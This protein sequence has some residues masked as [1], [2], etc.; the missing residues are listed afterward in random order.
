MAVTNVKKQEQYA[1]PQKAV[2]SNKPYQGMNGITQS[3]RNNLGNYQQGYK[4]ADTV[5]QAQQRV[6]QVQAQ[7]PQSYNSKYSGA[8]DS[9]LQQ[10]Q[11]PQDFKY[12]FNGDNLFKYYADLYTQKGRQASMDAMG[13]AAALTGGYGNSWAQAAGNQAYQQ[14]LLDLYGVGMDMRDRAYQQYQDQQANRQNTYN[15]LRDAQ[16]TEY[17]QYRDTVGDWER[18][19]DRA[20]QDYQQ[21]RAFDY[22]QYGDMLNYYTQLA[23]IENAAYNTEA[24]RQEAIRQFNQNFA[25]QQRQYNTTLAEQQR[26]Y[27]T[28]D[29]F[30]REQFGWQRDTDARDFA[31]GQRQYN[32]SLAE[33]Q[34]QADL[35]EAY[36]QAA[37]AWSQE[38]SNRNFGEQQRQYDTSLAEQQRQAN[39]DEAYRRDTLSEQQRQA[40]LDETYRRDTLAEQQRQA[41]LDEAY[42]QAALAWSQEESNRNFG[43]Q[44]RQFDIDNAYRNAQFDWQRSTDARDFAEQQRQF[45]ANFAQSV[46]EFNRTNELN[47]A[48]MQQDQDQ[49]EANMTEEQRQYNRNVAINYVTDI[50]KNG[51]IP[52]NAL[53]VA[54]GLTMEDAQRLIAEMVPAGRGAASTTPKNGTEKQDQIMGKETNKITGGVTDPIK[55]DMPYQQ[56]AQIAAGQTAVT[57]GATTPAPTEQKIIPPAQSNPAVGTSQIEQKPQ[58]SP[59]LIKMFTSLPSKTENK[60]TQPTTTNKQTSGSTTTNSGSWLSGLVGNAVNQAKNN[61]ANTVANAVA[62]AGKKTTAAK[63]TSTASLNAIKKK[64]NLNISKQRG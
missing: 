30:R 24:E 7:R 61:L 41:D 26:Q 52:S 46:E 19:L 9:I 53:L 44:Q 29:A 25:E 63:S 36:R 6:Q 32:E 21:E 15:M 33:Q 57:Q 42:R 18:E 4:P 45:D 1:Q 37:L 60:N 10:V 49:F 50:L 13:Q 2:Q 5:T 40:D 64:L 56:A 27:N 59:Q 16:Q 62:S 3:T 48:R 47:W 23:Q 43:E 22:G 8:L 31:E 55:T 51:Q 20:S 34:R 28:D 11:N 38:E 35:D 17:G 14:Y 54:A 58:V 12:E 39:L